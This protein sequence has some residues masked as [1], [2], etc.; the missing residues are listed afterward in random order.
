MNEEKTTATPTPLDKRRTATGVPG[1]CL[2][3][4]HKA[5]HTRAFPCIDCRWEESTKT[6]THYK[7]AP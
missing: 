5:V 2:S 4:K 6:F 3:C 7:A 1:T